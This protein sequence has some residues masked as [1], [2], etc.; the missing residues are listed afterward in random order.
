MPDLGNVR[1]PR[2]SLGIRARN[3]WPGAAVGYG[4]YFGHI[5]NATTET[6]LTQ[7]WLTEVTSASSHLTYGWQ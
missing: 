3:R 6:A 4:M 7:T 5:T 2:V 1:P